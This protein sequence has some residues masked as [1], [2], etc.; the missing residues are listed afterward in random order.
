MVNCNKCKNWI[1]TSTHSYTRIPFTL[2]LLFSDDVT[3]FMCS[4]QFRGRY[5]NGQ[6]WGWGIEF[7]WEEFDACYPDKWRRCTTECSTLDDRDCTPLDDEEVVV[8]Q[9]SQWK[10]TVLN[11]EEKCTPYWAWVDWGWAAITEQ[12]CG[13]IH[14][15]GCF[16]SMEVSLLAASMS[17]ISVGRNQGLHRLVWITVQ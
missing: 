15:A 4:S 11:T 8:I 12:S 9:T 2:W 16:S 10:T 17:Q 7:C 1:Q 14:F 13:E 6:A 5:C 3:V